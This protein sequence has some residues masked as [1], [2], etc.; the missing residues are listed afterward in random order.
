MHARLRR[1]EDLIGSIQ[2]AD[3]PLANFP[4][5]ST[6]AK[7][8][9]SIITMI[10]IKGF[11]LELDLMSHRSKKWWDGITSDLRHRQTELYDA[12]VTAF[13]EEKAQKNV[14]SELTNDD[15]PVVSLIRDTES[16]PRL[17]TDRGIEE[18]VSG[19]DSTPEIPYESPLANGLPIL[20][21]PV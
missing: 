13:L 14:V 17:W 11:P 15:L 4:M 21:H 5:R 12:A 6:P 1:R 19:R 7:Q 20:L 18:D 9:K 3:H 2:K 16:D 10:K 8:E